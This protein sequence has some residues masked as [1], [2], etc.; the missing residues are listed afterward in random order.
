MEKTRQKA[1][2][3]VAGTGGHGRFYRIEVRPKGEFV[4]FRT[5]DVGKREGLERVA[6]KRPSG[7]WDT[8]TWLVE[9]K[10]AH[11]SGGELII[12]DPKARTVLK[13]IRGRIIHLDGDVFRAHPRRNAPE[14]GK[15][16]PAQ[17]RARSENMKKAR[18]ARWGR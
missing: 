3:K 4:T 12:D 16:T 15:P 2:R 1:V 13:Q 11:V 6:G 9:K 10:D 14:R 8:A 7:S 17:I 5:Q 18:A